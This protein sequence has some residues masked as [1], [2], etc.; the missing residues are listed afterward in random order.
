MRGGDAPWGLV[1]DIIGADTVLNLDNHRILV[2]WMS[3]TMNRMHTRARFCE[4]AF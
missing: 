2:S 1:M 3:Y 4:Q